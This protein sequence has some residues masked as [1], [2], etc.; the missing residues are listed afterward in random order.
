MKMSIDRACSRAAVALRCSGG[1]RELLRRRAILLRRGD[2]G[3]KNFL[4]TT[5]GCCTRGGYPCIMWVLPFERLN[6]SSRRVPAGARTTAGALVVREA[7]E[8]PNKEPRTWQ[9]KP[10]RKRPRRRKRPRSKSRK[11]HARNVEEDLRTRAGD[12]RLLSFLCALAHVTGGEG[13]AGGHQDRPAPR[14]ERRRNK[15]AARGRR[16]AQCG[17][18]SA[19]GR[20]GRR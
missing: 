10:P 7:M 20:S 3:Y 18:R 16:P 9:R 11:R 12:R 5:K 1:C 17:S 4:H 15:T 8:P 13:A 14:A 19:G 6:T 2:G